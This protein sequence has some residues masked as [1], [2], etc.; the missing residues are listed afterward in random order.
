MNILYLAHRIP[1]PPDKGDKIR[2]FHQVRQ[3]SQAHNVHVL[4]FCDAREDLR[5]EAELRRYCRSVT[6]VPIDRSI[7]KL[8]AV[9]SIFKGEPWSL[10]Y[11][12]S[13]KM[14][15]AVKAR[16]AEINFDAIVGYSSSVAPY[17]QSTAIPKV[18]DLVDCDS[19]KWAQ[20]AER[21]QAPYRWLY[22]YEARCLRDYELSS[23]NTFDACVFV[24]NKETSRY[25][26][27]S[28]SRVHHIQ[29]GIDLEFFAPAK[30]SAASQ[31]VVF[32]GAMDYFPNVDA[33]TFYAEE[34]HPA[35]RQAIPD[36][37]FVIVGS[38]PEARVRALAKLPGVEV[39]GTVPD[40][41]PYLAGARVA[42]TPLRISQGI[43]NK[44]LE[45]LA[46]GLPVIASPAAAAALSQ[47]KAAPLSVANQTED[48]IRLVTEALRKPLRSAEEVELCRR[49]LREHYDWETNM[50]AFQRLIENVAQSGGGNS[51]KHMAQAAFS[52]SV[53]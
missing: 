11:F 23:L 14:A 35:I 2:S 13:P 7:Q 48:Y 30:L 26:A 21:F 43:Q 38:K 6:L 50:S 29:N 10:G 42:V 18:L 47:L 24:S 8:R 36:T 40:V 28:T 19:A 53:S 33:V 12:S 5:F 39:T 1:Y 52:R 4:A 37:Q 16:L 3:L 44:V 51:G 22:R 17:I 32:T 27:E 46:V 41:R 31:R 34:V 20:Y 25:P 49:E 15:A 45:A 9:A